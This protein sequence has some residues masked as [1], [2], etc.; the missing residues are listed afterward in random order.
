MRPLYKDVDMKTLY[1]MRESGMSNAEIANQ[2]GV[3]S[4]TIHNYIGSC[5]K[6]GG[7]SVNT[8]GMSVETDHET[9]TKCVL[10]VEKLQYELAGKV[11]RYQVDTGDKTFTLLAGDSSVTQGI[12]ALSTEQIPL[13]ISEL[14]AV[15]RMIGG[16]AA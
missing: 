13:L 11:C 14:Q 12:V 6:Q 4:R 1:A 2:L 3:C 7:A 8:I 10:T 9:P 16:S 15:L 5:K